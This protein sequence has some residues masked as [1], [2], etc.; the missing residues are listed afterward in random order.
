MHFD[1]KTFTS[2]IKY[3]FR[4]TVAVCQVPQEFVVAQPSALKL[5][6]AEGRGK[7]C[8][9]IVLKS[10]TFQKKNSSLVGPHK[11]PFLKN[12]RKQKSQVSYFLT[13]RFFGGLASSS[14]T[15]GFLD[16]LLFRSE[17]SALPLFGLLPSLVPGCFFSMNCLDFLFA[18]RQ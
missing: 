11:N 10:R 18:A 5:S 6:G 2:K 17:G 4:F 13:L 3:S 8:K 14:A 16:L 7:H 9:Q 1:F 12:G 15:S